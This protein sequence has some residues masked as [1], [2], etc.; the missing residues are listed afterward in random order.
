MKTRSL[1]AKF[2]IT[3]LIIVLA[4]Q[5]IG[6]VL[7]VSSI[8]KNL[9]DSLNG[10]I[11][12]TGEILSKITIK[13]I[14]DKDDSSMSAYLEE[15][16][17]DDDLVSISVFDK[18]QTLIAEKT[19]IYSREGRKLN[20]LYVESYLKRDFPVFSGNARI[21]EIAIMSSSSRINREILKQAAFGALHQGLLIMA[22][23]LLVAK[24]FSSD[25]RK[26]VLDFNLAVGRLGAGDL[27]ASFQS[28]KNIEM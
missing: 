5:G 13:P 15:L 6:F 8:R 11:Q 19:K 21:G 27:T 23:I 24:F 4:G 18:D 17:K 14:L 9:L 12:H 10:K 25:V 1:A 20:P 26:P 3:F 22:V 7:F 2:T 28:E 16:I